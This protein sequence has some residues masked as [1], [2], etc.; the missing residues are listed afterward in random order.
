MEIRSND[1]LQPA[2]NSQKTISEGLP[3]PTKGDKKNDLFA[4]KLNSALTSDTKNNEKQNPEK[5]APEKAAPEKQS[6]REKKTAK[7]VDDER[8]PAPS[9]TH[10]LRAQNMQPQ[11]ANNKS[12]SS[13]KKI[14][15][16]KIDATKTDT[17]KIDA[18]KT[19]TTKV[20]APKKIDASS[21]NEA[22]SPNSD[23]LS[24]KSDDGQP[25]TS[26][27]DTHPKKTIN[28]KNTDNESDIGSQDNC[29]DTDNSATTAPIV[30]IVP[31]AGVATATATA[32]AQTSP[33]LLTTVTP[34]PL[35]AT[36]ATSISNTT[37]P[38]ANTTTPFSNGT[39]LA[40]NQPLLT[41]DA[42]QSSG[43]ASSNYSNETMTVGSEISKMMS[44]FPNASLTVEKTAEQ[45]PDFE[46]F[47]NTLLDNSKLN[48]F[49]NSFIPEKNAPQN[50]N[51]ELELAS[52][53]SKN[54][55]SYATTLKQNPSAEMAQTFALN[56]KA[57]NFNKNA[58]LMQ[59]QEIGATQLFEL[60]TGTK[61]EAAKN[62]PFDL[63]KLN[64]ILNSDATNTNTNTNASTNAS[65]A[66][67]AIATQQDS[68]AT[69]GTSTPQ[70]QVLASAAN[71]SNFT[72]AN[73]EF[74]N[75]LPTPKTS[76]Q[77]SVTTANKVSSATEIKDISSDALT[78]AATL[79]TGSSREATEKDTNKR[80]A[81]SGENLETPKIDPAAAKESAS[82]NSQ[83]DV[84]EAK[85]NANIR[86]ETAESLSKGAMHR[87]VQ[88]AARLQSQGGGTARIQLNDS[89][90]GNIDL[91]VTVTS[92]QNVHI[93]IKSKDQKL[94]STLEERMDDLKTSLGQ[95]KL[96]LS[97]C[98]VISETAQSRNETNS[99]NENRGEQQQ[100][101]QQANAWN[102]S[103]QQNSS[104]DSQDSQAYQNAEA[105]KVG[106][107]TS[108]QS[109]NSNEAN[110]APKT[111]IQRGANGSLKVTA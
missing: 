110:I 35:N 43:A 40:Q 33:N 51:I 1:L 52:L 19:D 68:N 93:E 54:D 95:H 30:P 83:R 55:A 78:A 22:T 48:N 100:M 101:Q 49:S 53:L 80:D 25:K 79:P 94:R 109:K 14:D 111:N 9:P 44:L 5:A 86:P 108:R 102:N 20:D 41:P 58:L 50:K 67:A 97:E 37:P 60:K 11:A 10:T 64:N 42:P 105:P 88:T 8:N 46:I 76:S 39:T 57:D 27:T 24:K 82:L 81:R 74:T 17:T 71:V 75:T 15:T 6:L 32:A 61:L 106:N 31:T 47:P 4:E 3:T 90:L 84:S 85:E 7:K 104:Q 107:P 69:L 77:S 70:Q 72:K 73:K 29:N 103:K 38:F 16:T 92:G 66:A 56:S 91:R 36:T 28:A 13:T 26:N 12:D 23:N 89:K 63:G 45:N 21:R 2:M 65:V 87:A 59:N 96:N 62:A 99:R 18:T 34:P 98:R